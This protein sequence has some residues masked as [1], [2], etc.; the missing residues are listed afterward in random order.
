MAL[1][2]CPDQFWSF[3]S[4][5]LTPYSNRTCKDTGRL[6]S[7][8]ILR[9]VFFLASNSFDRSCIFLLFGSVTPLE[10]KKEGQE[11]SVSIRA[12]TTPCQKIKSKFFKLMRAWPIWCLHIILA[13]P[14]R[15]RTAVIGACPVTTHCIVAMS[16]CENNDNNCT[17]HPQA[18][19]YC[20]RAAD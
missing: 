7:L 4:E 14:G 1:P 17:C 19:Q 20:R 15:T 18:Q 3:Y 11:A 5:I 16:S 9:R 13:G 8:I 2:R 6:P 10:K 12:W